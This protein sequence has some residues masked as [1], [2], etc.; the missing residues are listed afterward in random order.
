[1]RRKKSPENY[2][3]TVLEEIVPGLK[4]GKSTAVDSKSGI[5][6][7]QVYVLQVFG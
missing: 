7:A 5:F 2:V 3:R 4:T 1:M 6:A